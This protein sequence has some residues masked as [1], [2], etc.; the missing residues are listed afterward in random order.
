[1]LALPCSSADEALSPE[2]P[3]RW[4][5][6][7]EPWPWGSIPTAGCVGGWDRRFHAQLRLRGLLPG[8]LHAAGAGLPPVGWHGTAPAPGERGGGVPPHLHHGSLQELH[9]LEQRQEGPGAVSP[10][11]RVIDTLVCSAA[12]LKQCPLFIPGEAW[13][14]RVSSS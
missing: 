10:D 2:Q 3:E 9:G 6:R 14:Y 7:G 13:P 11:K 12:D 5:R 1:M 8:D 4:A